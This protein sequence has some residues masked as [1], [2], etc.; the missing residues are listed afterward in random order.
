MSESRDSKGRFGPGNPGRPKGTRHKVT[1]AAQRLLEKDGRALARKAIELALQGDTTALKL[2]I[3]R[4][5]PPRKDAPVR[6]D[7]PDIRPA[8]DATQAAGA[9]LEAVSD[10]HL[11]PMEGAQVMGLV[12]SFRRVLE[13]T[14]IERRL[15]RLEAANANR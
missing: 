7:L 9:I 2:C 12:D 5:C 3:D 15:S 6:F 14:E 1:V 11:T 4:I 10:S 13:S 8:E